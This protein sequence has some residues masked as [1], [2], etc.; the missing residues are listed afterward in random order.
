MV[1]KIDQREKESRNRNLMQLLKQSLK[2]IFSKKQA[3][4]LYLFFSLAEREK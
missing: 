1:E 2:L 3:D 4:I